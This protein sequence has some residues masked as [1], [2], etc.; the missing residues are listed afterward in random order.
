MSSA[1]QIEPSPQNTPQGDRV[2]EQT[3][4][5]RLAAID[6]EARARIER[7]R[8]AS[9]QEIDAERSALKALRGDFDDF[10]RAG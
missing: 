5:D 6:E 7:H 2:R 10:R 3:G 1:T 9:R 8:H 4:P